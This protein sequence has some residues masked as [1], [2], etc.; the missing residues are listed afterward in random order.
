MANGSTLQFEAQLWIA[1]EQ[2]VSAPHLKMTESA[3]LQRA[4]HHRQSIL[5]KAFTGNL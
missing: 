1:A 5:Q 4:A 2:A 3:N